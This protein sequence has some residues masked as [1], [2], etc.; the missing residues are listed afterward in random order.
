MKAETT[1]L[2]QLAARIRDGDSS[3]VIAFMK[4]LEPQMACI[5][6]RVMRSGSAEST[7]AQRI[8]LEAGQLSAQGLK[9]GLLVHAIACRICR[10]AIAG[11]QSGR[12]DERYF[13]DTV[14]E[15]RGREVTTVR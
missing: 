1:E 9:G 10:G 3:A 7:I 8:V 2:R 12:A 15:S 13:L 4:H 6:R 11:L 5:V 14:I